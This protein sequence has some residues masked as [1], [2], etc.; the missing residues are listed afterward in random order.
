MSKVT[1]YLMTIT[2]LIFILSLGG[3]N[4]GQHW[5][6]EQTGLLNAPE[7]FTSSNFFLELIAVL[8][9]AGTATIVI[10]FFT[11]SSAKDV[12]IAGYLLFLIYFVAELI[13]IIIYVNGNFGSG[14]WSW[15]S[16][17]I[18]SV[19]GVLTIGYLSSIVD[20]YNG[21]T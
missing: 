4:T 11:K 20:Y 5:I 16:Y 8:A 3:I 21:G 15:V 12:L 13:N 1:N 17:A 10:G 19:F 9:L 7:N 6:L 2:G 18:L 14:S